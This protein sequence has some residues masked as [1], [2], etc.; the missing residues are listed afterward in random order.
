MMKNSKIDIN[1]NNE[2]I[3]KKELFLPVR[4]P[5]PNVE[6]DKLTGTYRK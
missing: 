2:K 6:K 4:S 3:E 1:K 5:G